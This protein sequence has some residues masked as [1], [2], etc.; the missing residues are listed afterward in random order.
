MRGQEI[1]G[2]L[3]SEEFDR[4]LAEQS[5]GGFISPRL[6]S[7]FGAGTFDTWS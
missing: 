6:S 3:S 5:F 7:G 1:E 4:A 2:Y